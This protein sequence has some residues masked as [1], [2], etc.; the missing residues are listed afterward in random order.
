MQRLAAHLPGAMVRS[1]AAAG[2]PPLQVEALAFA[3]L[4]RRIVARR[5]A[6]CR[7][8]PAPGPARAGSALPGGLK[9]HGARGSPARRASRAQAEKDDPQP[10]VVVAFGFLI[11]NCA[12][13]RSSL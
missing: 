7:R 11:T 9:Q 4:A 3:W 5:P 8:S 10:Q 12:P 6:T 2:V 13:C 1:T